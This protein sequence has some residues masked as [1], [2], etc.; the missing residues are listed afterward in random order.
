MRNA[1]RFLILFLISFPGFISGQTN[2]KGLLEKK[3][4]LSDV[5]FMI[6]NFEQIQVNA[7]LFISKKEL[8]AKVDS[9]F[10]LLPD[11]VP[12]DDAFV[13]ISQVAALIK[14]GHTYVDDD[15]SIKKKYRASKLFPLK[16]SS[17][18]ELKLVVGEKFISE[19]KIR[20]G[21]SLLSINGQPLTKLFH[22]SMN[23]TG[24]LTAYQIDEAINNFP[25]H[26]YL[27]KIYSPFILDYKNQSGQILT[28]TISGIS[29]SNLSKNNRT[30]Y[31]LNYSY[32]L[33]PG[34]PDLGYIDFRSMSGGMEKFK[35]FLDSCFIDLRKKSAKGLIVDLRYNGG[36]DSDYA[37]LLLS[38]LTDKSYRLSS[39][40]S[41]KVSHQYQEFMKKSAPD[42]SSKEVV[43]YLQSKPGSILSYEHKK[44]KY[45][46]VNPNRYQLKTCFLIGPQNMS[47]ATMLADGAQTYKLA[48]LIGEPTGA[49][50]NDGGEALSFQLPY[51]KFNVY[52]P[53][54]FDI[55]ANGD[56]KDTNAILPDIFI[57]DQ[58][59]SKNDAILNRAILWFADK[60]K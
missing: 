4:L 2:L 29:F 5:N 55:R 43:E 23:M 19:G 22:T 15:A 49:P 8:A 30:E 21:D 34:K 54:A 44:K 26:L 51:S 17:D 52:T 47:S 27:L 48:T 6:Q 18:F 25:Y 33:L 40:R 57:R 38:Y 1:F 58:Y 31:Q 3:Q 53:S 13:A 36:G 59:D 42:Q 60:K 12:I 10:K 32:K 35:L 11:T 24:G 14:D 56:D 50:A 28:D 9:I 37:E 41:F 45:L 20:P 39:R 16:L 46:A 7:Y